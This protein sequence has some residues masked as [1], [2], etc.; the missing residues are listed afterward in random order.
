MF[1]MSK[2]ALSSIVF[3]ERQTIDRRLIKH[4]DY[5]V[6]RLDRPPALPALNHSNLRHRCVQKRSQR[7]QIVFRHEAFGTSFLR[8]LPQILPVMVG[9]HQN[10]RLRIFLDNVHG[11]FQT[12]HPLHFPIHQNPIGKRF[13]VT[14]KRVESV[15]AFTEIVR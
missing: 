6:K 14:P 7:Q 12:V 5:E 13:F 3:T 8:R 10:L 4:I 2:R 11:C 15:V 9:H 1:I